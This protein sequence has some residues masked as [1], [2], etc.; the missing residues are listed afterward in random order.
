MDYGVNILYQLVDYVETATISAWD[1]IVLFFTAI[2]GRIVAAVTS[3]VTILGD[4][5]TNLWVTLKNNVI[6]GWNSIIDFIKAVPGRI[7]SFGDSFISAGKDIIRGFFS[8]LSSTG[9]FAEDV[10]RSIVN[11]FKSGL[12]FAIDNINSGINAVSKFVPGGLPTI[13]RV[14]SGG[15]IAGSTLLQAGERGSEL[16]LPLTGQRGRNRYTSLPG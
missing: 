1:S 3:L 13:P 10:G 9:G 6:S 2:P 5:F 16:V 11:T 4:F 15:L 7:T 8:G 12:N 14:Q